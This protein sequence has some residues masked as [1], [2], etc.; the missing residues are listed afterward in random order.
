[1]EMALGSQ[2]HQIRQELNCDVYAAWRKQ[3]PPREATVPKYAHT[4]YYALVSVDAFD[5]LT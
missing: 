2:I 3:R 5:K 1:M 4:H